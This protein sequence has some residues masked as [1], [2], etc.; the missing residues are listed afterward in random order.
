MLML[1]AVLFVS[2]TVFSGLVCPTTT[3]PNAT[4]VGE[5]VAGFM[6]VPL[7]ATVSGLLPALEA[8]VSVPAGCVPVAAGVIVTVIVQLELAASV[9]DP[10]L[11]HVPPVT[12]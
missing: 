11:G 6:P 10:V 4:D 8:I 7:S 3:L 9:P 5:I 12:A 1:A 2:V